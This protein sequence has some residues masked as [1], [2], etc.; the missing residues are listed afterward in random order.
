[1]NPRIFPSLVLALALPH[2]LHASEPLISAKQSIESAVDQYFSKGLKEAN[3]KPASG[4]NDAEFLRRLTLDLAGRIPTLNELNDFLSDSAPDKRTRW[5]DRLI[6]S[7]SFVRHQAQE[8]ATMLVIDEPGRRNPKTSQLVPYLRK[9]VETNRAWDQVFRDLIVP[10]ETDKS[11]EGANEFLK[12]RIKDL[13]RTAIDVSTLFFGVNVSCAQCHDHPHVEEWTQDHFYGMK[14]FFSRTVDNGGF[15]AEKSF[16][17]VKYIPVKGKGKGKERESPVMFVTGKVLEVPG[18]KEPNGAEKQADQKRLDQAKKDKKPAAPP[19]VSLRQKLV[20]TA[21]E[22]SQREVF[23]KSIVNRMVHRFFGHGLVMPLDQLHS[24]NPPSHPELLEWLARDLIAHNYDL[25]RLMRGLVSSEAYARQAYW[26][27]KDVPLPRVFARGLVRPLTPT[28]MALSL[29]IA[30]LDPETMPTEPTELNRKLEVLERS[31][32]KW[33]GFFPMVTEHFQVGV[34][35]AMLFANN[36]AFAK[37]LLDAPDSLVNRLLKEPDLAK[38]AEYAIRVVLNRTAFPEEVERLVA[39]QRA[40]QDR[41]RE[42]SQHMVWALLTS[43]EFRFN[44]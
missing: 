42:A 22:P 44:H 32:E 11:K 41:G 35:E 28:Q 1:M 10:D 6:A 7:P 36:E 34:N 12:S 23:A 25:R 37:E 24:E 33:V 38:R 15:L 27:E 14:S 20:E 43:A 16:G 18:M 30:T 19:E 9:S 4:M 13:N 29:R 5:I 31:S 39:F 2:V 21:L 26:N 3:L 17:V 8:F 40:R